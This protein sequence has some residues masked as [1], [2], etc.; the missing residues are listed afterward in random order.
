MPLGETTLP[1]TARCI[2]AQLPGP[3]RP[4]QTERRGET[5]REHG[6]GRVHSF[7][8]THPPP[9]PGKLRQELQSVFK[10]QIVTVGNVNFKSSGEAVTIF[11]IKKQ[12]KRTKNHHP[13]ASSQ[14]VSVPALPPAGARA[15]STGTGEAAERDRGEQSCSVY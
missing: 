13:S 11:Q 9:E 12:T 5:A 14:R 7:T 6:S 2:T 1:H 15:H 8:P 4:Q 3:R 10:Q